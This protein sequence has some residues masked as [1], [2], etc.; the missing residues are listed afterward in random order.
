MLPSR[1]RYDPYYKLR[2]TIKSPTDLILQAYE[3]PGAG[4]AEYGPP[5]SAEWSSPAAEGAYTPTSWAAESTP[6]AD[7]ASVSLLLLPGPGSLSVD[8]FSTCT[9]LD[10]KPDSHLGRILPLRCHRWRRPRG[11]P[12]DLLGLVRLAAS[13]GAHS[14]TSPSPESKRVLRA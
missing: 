6:T 8:T 10:F 9:C 1:P 3:A 11:L 5:A 4:T 12:R 13:I 7:W 14:D 2:L